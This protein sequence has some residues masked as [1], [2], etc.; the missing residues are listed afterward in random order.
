MKS[1]YDKELW[2][3][4]VNPQNSLEVATGGGDNTLRI[5]DIKNNQQKGFLMLN[6]DF[7]ALDWSSDGPL[8][9]YFFLFVLQDLL[10]QLLFLLLF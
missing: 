1:H 3:L 10:L 9:V 8:L 4:T 7:R 6:E 5:W 2:G